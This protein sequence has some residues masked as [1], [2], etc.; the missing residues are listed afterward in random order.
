MKIRIRTVLFGL[1][2]MGFVLL[3]VTILQASQENQTNSSPQRSERQN[4]MPSAQPFEG[5]LTETVFIPY[6][7]IP[8]QEDVV[9]YDRLIYF[10]IAPD[11]K[12]NIVSDAG[13]AELSQFSKLGSTSQETVLAVRMLNTETNVAVLEHPE[14]Q[15]LVIDNVSALM[16]ENGF[17]G[18]MLDLEYSALST[19]QT[20]TQIT[21]FVRLFSRAIQGVETE[22]G[23]ATFYLTAYGDTFYRSRPYN[24]QALGELSDGIMVMA[25]DFHKS[26]GEP[27]PNFPLNKSANYGYDFKTMITDFTSVVPAEKITVLF[28]MYGYD[29][30]LGNQGLPLKSAKA[31]PLR[32]IDSKGAIIKPESK[33]KYIKYQDDEGFNHELWYEDFESVEIKQDFIKTQG[34]GSVGYWVWGY[35]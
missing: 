1:G 30:T 22:S 8:S 10:G 32:E 25:Y 17:D 35:W 24:I 18:V 34:I 3:M 9:S 16:A 20:S 7:N 29:W 27:G 6:W 14:V 26:R 21:D 4:A 15:Q 23:T 33:E 2:L 19:G 11:S 28:G 13:K 5:S 12:G 31:V